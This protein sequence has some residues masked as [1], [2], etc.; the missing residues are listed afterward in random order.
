MYGELPWRK[1]LHGSLKLSLIWWRS[2]EDE[3][4]ER[5]V[6]VLFKTEEKRGYIYSGEKLGLKF[7][8]K[9]RNCPSIVADFGGVSRVTFQQHAPLRK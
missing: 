8:V 4:R 2:E 5:E 6:W 3:E 7:G 9:G 1:N